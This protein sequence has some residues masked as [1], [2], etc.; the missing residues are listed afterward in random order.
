MQKPEE[1]NNAIHARLKETQSIVIVSHIRPD[2]DAV[3]SLLGLG[4][5]LIKA[6]KQV[7]MVLEDGLPDK[8]DDLKYSDLVVPAIQR[9]FDMLI[10]VDSSDMRRTGSELYG[11]K[12]PDLCI[13]HH[14]TNL[15]FAKINLIEEN[16]VATAAI[17]AEHMS[18]WGLEIDSDVASSLLVG[19]IGDTIGFRTSNMNAKTLRLSADLMD[20]GADLPKLYQQILVSRTFEEMRYWGAGLDKLTRKDDLIWTSL[21][22]DDRIKCE[23]NENDDADLINILSSVADVKIAMIFVQ[24]EGGSIK[25]S[26]RA[27]PGIDVSRVAFS[28]GGGGHAAASGADIQ[29][30]LYDVMESVIRETKTLLN[31]SFDRKNQVK[32]G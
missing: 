7:Q 24:Q 31:G 29:G 19:I 20:K 2:A 13:D 8:Y 16:A 18:F 15:M 14:K 4:Q 22:L 5:A 9:V 6:G 30:E 26:W 32:R 17:L 23:Y 12:I 25:V 1:V 3:G 27:I 11:Y 21:T 28:F 10:V